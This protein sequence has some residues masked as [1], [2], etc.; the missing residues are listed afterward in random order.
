MHVTPQQPSKNLYYLQFLNGQPVWGLMKNSK[1]DTLNENKEYQ[2]QQNNQGKLYI[3]CRFI[4]TS[5]SY[6]S[7][8]LDSASVKYEKS[9]NVKDKKMNKFRAKPKI[10]AVKNGKLDLFCSFE[11]YKSRIFKTSSKQNVKP[12]SH[13]ESADVDSAK[14]MFSNTDVDPLNITFNKSGNKK[15]VKDWPYKDVEVTNSTSAST[16]KASSNRRG[17]ADDESENTS[18]SID[19]LV[20]TNS[21][22]QSSATRGDGKSKVSS[23]LTTPHKL[24]MSATDQS[25]TSNIDMNLSNGQFS[26]LVSFR[27]WHI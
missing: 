16:K 23:V 1:Q 21:N 26:Q 19:P 17:Q 15:P 22:I 7:S 18:F 9:P 25:Q 27:I 5:R 2:H 12:S 3:A 14:C 6:K 8:H 11:E 24:N 10:K 13:A 4:I 20:I